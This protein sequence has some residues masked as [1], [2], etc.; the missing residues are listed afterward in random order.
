MRVLIAVA[1]VLMGLGLFSARG[2]QALAA[3][4]GVGASEPGLLD[5]ALAT[6]RAE[7]RAFQRALSERVRAVQTDGS[8]SAAWALM[9]ASFV[10]G[11]LHAAG[12]GHGKV[13]ISAYAL[14]SE[15]LLRRALWLSGLSALVQALSAVVLVYGPL[16]VLGAFLRGRKDYELWLERLSYGLIAAVGLWLAWTGIKAVV[17][18]RRRRAAQLRVPPAQPARQHAHPASEAGHEHSDACQHSHG[19]SP[20]AVA[21]ARDWREMAGI[22]LAVGVRPCTGAILV[23]VF[24]AGLGLYAVGIAA[25]LAMAVGSALAVAIIATGAY[26]LG[27]LG[28]RF[29]LGQGASLAAVAPSLRIA[30]GTLLVAIACLLFLATYETPASPLSF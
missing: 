22:A 17:A 23:L 14:T 25:V 11:V 2:P 26:G 18:W 3:P 27:R 8:L 16:L 9:V 10:Y 20:E 6:L 29:A 5:Q 19:P 4:P 30:G 24:A 12:P 7:Q 13:V 1:L 21:R 15:R 28:E